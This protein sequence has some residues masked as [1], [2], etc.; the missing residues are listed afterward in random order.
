MKKI[1]LFSIL[2]LSFNVIFADNM[3]D[4]NKTDAYLI[5]HVISE[6]EHLPNVAIIIKGTNLATYTDATG[7]YKM[8]NIP[9]GKIT[10]LVKSFGFISEE[11]T[12]E[13]KQ[14]QTFEVNFE[15]KPDNI[16]IEQVIV[17]GDKTEMN[18]AEAPMLVNV[19]STKLISNSGAVCG[20]DV[21]NFQP[22][23]RVETNCQN[24]GVSQL[25]M[26]GMEGAYSH[27]LINSRPIFS[28]LNGVYGL[29]QIPAQMIDRIEIV[30]GGGSAL[31]GGNAI[32]GTVNIIT[33]EPTSN[34][35]QINSGLSLINGTTPDYNAGFNTS[36]VS[37]DLKTGL[38]IFGIK[39]N[40]QPYYANS[41][42]FSE[43]P[44][45]N[46]NA[47]GFS[48]FH[49]ITNQSK[50]SIDFHN[51]QEFR[52]GGNKFDKL[53]HFS[54]ITEQVD[55]DIMGGGIT[56][57]YLSKNYKT[58]FS[59]FLTSQ[60]TGRDS[61]Y[62]AEQD[63]SAYGLTEDFSFV[64][65]MQ[66]S[67]RFDKVLISPMKFIFG[68]ENSYTSLTDKKLGYFDYDEDTQIE[69]R[70]IVNQQLITPGVYSQTEW[71]LNK[72][73]LLVGARYDVP[74]KRLN[75]TPVFMP[76]ANLLVKLNKISKIR[77][78]YAKGYRAP[79]IFNEDLH[80]E[81]SAARQIIH[82]TSD[83]LKAEYSNSYSAS[84]DFTKIYDFV[85]TYILIEGF[86][87]ILKNPFSSDFS[88]DEETK[89]MTMN[90]TN[91]KSGAFVQG[92][93]FESKFAFSKKLELQ[94]GGT[95]QKS[96]Y[97]VAQ[98]WSE[99]EALVTKNF[100]RSPNSYGYAVIY[101][102]PFKNTSI[103]LTGNYTGKMYVPHFAGGL[104]SA[105]NLITE[106]QLVE[107]KPFYDAGINISQTIK[108]TNETKIQFS[109]GVKNIFN[110]YQDDFD[111]GIYRDAGYVYGPLL[112]RTFTFGLKLGKF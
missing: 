72:F 26:N 97:E 49:K 61:Y 35:F 17:S 60:H 62:G 45:I 9:V 86:H 18:R 95:V 53:P 22:G 94:L 56:Y 90:K 92:I 83:D 82:T 93:N 34:S 32:A 38:F 39:R 112:P 107:T 59:V 10:I 105:G 52:R 84:I 2:L 58:N 109:V 74:D 21:L 3:P 29:E 57:D 16:N 91:A 111:M 15:L 1:I 104:N 66:F 30:R 68:A 44:L 101:Y 25:R 106:D 11:Y 23:L 42:D 14:K 77:L 36:L 4:T 41:D 71:E 8:A 70:I 99:D 78:S 89:I 96:E 63:L 28:A 65:G 48:A 103:S 6:G 33:K 79:Q 75:V 12:I 85:Q 20:V 100:T 13:V 98:P 46:S 102:D 73:K 7:H 40:R 54:D 69:D 27:V 31:F 55:H 37:D 19:I 51:I 47:Y 5:G 43:I 87:T 88:F 64:S 50:I 110:S 24:C 67:H 81:T 108:I 76:R 80:I